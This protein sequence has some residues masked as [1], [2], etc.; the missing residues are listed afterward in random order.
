MGDAAE[1]VNSSITFT[2]SVILKNENIESIEGSI[3]FQ[4]TNDTFQGKHLESDT[5]GEVWRPISQNIA[6][7]SEY[8]LIKVGTNL[9]VNDNGAL[10]S[11]APESSRILELIITVS[12]FFGTAD[13]TDIQTAINDAIGTEAGGYT[14]GILTQPGGVVGEAPSETYQFIIL[15]A[16]G[17]YE[18]DTPIRLAPFTTLRGINS[19]NS[20]IKYNLDS[21]LISDYASAIILKNNC[22]I[23]NL[24]I[25]LDFND[26]DNF[27]LS[28]ITAINS[29]NLS[30]RNVK[31][32][33]VDK[34]YSNKALYGI[35]LQNVNNIN[36]DELNIS[37]YNSYDLFVGVYIESSLLINIQ[38]SKIH[39][40]DK[41]NNSFNFYGIFAINLNNEVISKIINNEILINSAFNNYCII[42]I[43]SSFKIKF[44]K[45]IS[46]YSSGFNNCLLLSG[47]SKVTNNSNNILFFSHYDNDKDIITSSNTSIV[48][49][50]NLGFLKDSCVKI[51]GSVNNDGVY[52]IFD[53][54][55]SRL[56]LY[57]EE[58]LINESISPIDITIELLY[59]IQ[60]EQNILLSNRYTIYSFAN[61][62]YSIESIR[63]KFENQDELIEL[64][65]NNII[66]TKQ[67]EIIV[68]NKNSDYFTISQAISN[69]S[70]NSRFN[71][72]T[73]YVQPG[74]YYETTT[75]TIPNFVSIIGSGKANTI[76]N[77][78]KSGSSLDFNSACFRINNNVDLKN[79][80][81]NN[82]SQGDN[83]SIIIYGEGTG[84]DN[85]LTD[86]FLENIKII[87]SGTSTTKYGCYL[88][89]VSYNSKNLNVEVNGNNN[90]DINNYGIYEKD[91]EGVHR[92][93]KVEVLDGNNSSKNV[94]FLTDNSL[95]EIYSSNIYVSGSDTLNIGIETLDET[96]YYNSLQVFNSIINCRVGSGFNNT[97]LFGIK[98]G[99][100]NNTNYYLKLNNCLIEGEIVNNS[101]DKLFIFDSYRENSDEVISVGQGRSYLPISK[102]GKTDE[103]S[104]GSL[105]IGKLVGNQNMTGKFNSLIGDNVN[106]SLTTGK[107]NTSFGSRIG[108]SIETGNENTLIGFNSGDNLSTNSNNNVIINQI[109]NGSG[110]FSGINDNICIG[111]NTGI[112]FENNVVGNVLIGSNSGAN[113]SIYNFGDVGTNVMIGNYSGYKT[114]DPIY[115]VIIGSNVGKVNLTSCI[116]TNTLIGANVLQN[117]SSCFENTIIGANSYSN[118]YST[119]LR[120]STIIGKNSVFDSYRNYYNNILGT[121]VGYG[122]YD[123]EGSVVIGYNAAYG[124]AFSSNKYNTII[125]SESG[126]DIDGAL[127][128]V[129]IGSK[130]GDSGTD[131][132]KASGYSLINGENNVMLGTGAGK[133]MTTGDNNVLI[134]GNSGVGIISSSDNVLI[135]NYTGENISSTTGKN[136]FIGSNTGGDITTSDNLI[137]GQY[138]GELNS[139]TYNTLIGYEAG[140]YVS[141][142][143][144]TFLGYQSGG[145]KTIEKT[146]NDNLCIGYRTGYNMTSA[147]NNVVIG[148]TSILILEERYT[149]GDLTT[150]SNNTIIGHLTG[151]RL[152]TQENN[153]LIGNGTAKN[154]T[155]NNNLFIGDSIGLDT[156][157]DDNIAIGYQTYRNLIEGEK[158]LGIGYQAG[159]RN[160]EGD[161]N[162][163]IGYTAGNRNRDGNYNINVGDEAGYY[164]RGSNNI[165]MGTRAGYINNSEISKK[166]ISIG[167]ESGYFNN[168]GERNINLGR[169]TGKYNESG[170]KNI[171]IGDQ[172]G[173]GDELFSAN[174]N[175]LIGINSGKNNKGAQHIYIGTSDDDTISGSDVNG[176]GVGYNST[177]LSHKNIYIGSN[178]GIENTDGKFNIGIGCG[179]MENNLIGDENISIGFISGQ[180]I[181]SGLKNILIGYGSGL[182]LNEGDDNIFIG[183]NSGANT[184]SQINNN[185]AI[186][187]NSGKK[188]ET[189]NFI[190][191]GNNSGENNTTGENNI[192]IGTNAGKNLNNFNNNILIGLNNGIAY[193]FNKNVFNGDSY[194]TLP[195]ENLSTLFNGTSFSIS[196]Y[197]SLNTIGTSQAFFSSKFENTNNRHLHLVRRSYGNI[198]FAFWAND[199]ESNQVVDDSDIRHYTFTYDSM[200][201]YRAIYIN[202]SLDTSDNSAS[203]L[204]ILSFIG[205]TYIGYF[206]IGDEWKLNGSLYDLRIFNYSLDASQV[207]N[208]FSLTPS[209]Y[210]PLEEN[211]NSLPSNDDYNGINNGVS[212]TNTDTDN[213]LIG[214]NI[215]KTSISGRQNICLGS[216][217]FTNG[218][219]SNNI[220]MGN[221]VGNDNDGD[222]NIA[223]GS[224]ALYSNQ[225]G[226]FNITLGKDAGFSLNS[227]YK[228]FLGTNSGYTSIDD[229]HSIGLGTNVLKSLTNSNYNIGIGN[230]SL[231]NINNS[232]FYGNNFALGTNTLNRNILSINNV[233]IGTNAGEYLDIRSQESFYEGNNLFMGTNAGKFIQAHDN[234]FIGNNV[235][236]GGDTEYGSVTFTSSKISFHRDTSNDYI[237]LSDTSSGDFQTSGIIDSPFVSIIGATNEENQFIRKNRY[238]V[239]RDISTAQF[240][241]LVD[242]L[243]GFSTLTEFL[244]DEP[245]GNEI[246]MYY[247]NVSFGHIGMGQNVL[248]NVYGA[249]SN[250]IFGSF[251]GESV[252]I[253]RDLNLTGGLS[254]THI[255]ETTQSN[256]IGYGSGLGDS[257]G[258][259]NTSIGKYAGTLYYD[260]SI[261]YNK[262]NVG[263]IAIGDY[264]LGNL[265]GNFTL[266]PLNTSEYR[267]RQCCAI[268]H[269][270]SANSG[271]NSTTITLAFNTIIGNY[272]GY[273]IDEWFNCMLGYGSGYYSQG[274]RNIY[275]GQYTGA[276]NVNGGGNMF[277]ASN[278]NSLSSNLSVS[279]NNT[280]AVYQS[281]ALNSG[282]L[283]N[284][285][286]FG[287]IS[288]GRLVIN[289]RDYTTTSETNTKL[290]VNGDVVAYGYTPFTGIHHV[291]YS[292]NL[293]LQEG[294]IL[295]SSSGGLVKK[296][297]IVN[298]KITV[299]VSRI[300]KDKKVYGIYCGVETKD[301]GEV[302]YNV[303]SVGEG[304]MLITNIGGEVQNGDY[305]SSSVIPGF[306]MKQ[307][308]DL[309]HSYTVAKCT[310][311]IDWNSIT[312]FIEHDGIQ[313]KRY[314]CGCTYHCG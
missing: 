212:F 43:N 42:L 94:G 150:G 51:T 55:S 281:D 269:F 72:Y 119:T 228:I 227:D 168:N 61:S 286:L 45:L 295:S 138:A 73:I 251:A 290:F 267:Y 39:I 217:V 218:N 203:S 180:N 268:G 85:K 140:Y 134:G 136:I 41:N 195:H 118:Q 14:D 240:L 93:T 246:F 90:T 57:S 139:A 252:T 114:T 58:I 225:N 192:L 80:T 66:Y 284:P 283:Y 137:I 67:N 100:T 15:L 132:D 1:I 103:T 120:E 310:E 289:A 292:D 187:T 82:T 298:T 201:G 79:L 303:A 70:Y 34:N 288:N 294:M 84:I 13:Y 123:N 176:K 302:D 28:G 113:V 110:V 44:N 190:G 131:N 107:H 248:R 83:Y 30:I 208:I 96:T 233:A 239:N 25:Q 77:F 262:K 97:S 29:N 202:Q 161:Y 236:R 232:G 47:S 163:N 282:S 264:S 111:K 121:N 171:C 156:T 26:D 54:D 306:G 148:S 129:V 122:K 27:D 92:Y 158:N 238:W 235:G 2:N 253:G 184:S 46:N 33:T 287:D 102:F 261:N 74:I 81:I 258:I 124:T 49:F 153:I 311:E 75:I 191:F 135:G 17:L 12:P 172:S 244:V 222:D 205:N 40:T 21:N 106:T 175:I 31:I 87:S 214:N 300:E 5:E 89:Y 243:N 8:G 115:N 95:V 241:F 60:L 229:E 272:A 254:G 304:C 177:I 277:L 255:L 237:Y 157:S 105:L 35:Y 6:S 38:N 250:C 169:N 159:L 48:N 117:G 52:K 22:N 126:Y 147:S 189:D 146:G 167:Y 309:Q 278:I 130:S 86:I 16:P 109:N 179:S 198:A 234:C 230:K 245:E 194:I 20:I 209:I 266:N 210:Y 216:N 188:L 305:I 64:N 301:D 151:S 162:L 59:F 197:A 155:G 112:D 276:N 299:S 247:H 275:I 242:S 170:V 63:N 273:Y 186:G 19:N 4:D 149:G 9:T 53:V 193:Q 307:D 116:F 7:K 213:I 76:I 220:L 265:N 263:C 206:D 62:Y 10:N 200:T 308:D 280:F 182:N 279:L 274:N 231:E 260:K 185:I 133:R 256:F 173:M 3:R 98:H 164:S 293:D 215:S 18:I 249:T 297:D 223:M 219:G 270:A 145:N 141:G 142:D 259:F 11:F 68:G 181:N 32:T 199:L 178:S 296:V 207:S 174:K 78:N 285:L 183:S 144:N 257:S 312:D 65:G 291:Y 204:T 36:I 99:D 101:S 71:R 91:C 314:L 128:N 154:L 125:G 196:F 88:E 24:Q 37:S 152:T 108:N 271:L 127:Y 50:E 104:N 313:Y 166:N 221:N 143:R 56:I 23:E 211:A 224:N 226:D 69:I 160:V 165:F